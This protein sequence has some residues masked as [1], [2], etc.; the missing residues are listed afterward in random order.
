MIEA[1]IWRDPHAAVLFV[2]EAA[3]TYWRVLDAGEIKDLVGFGLAMFEG[4]AWA[5]R[6]LCA[7]GFAQAVEESLQGFGAGD[8][9]SGDWRKLKTDAVNAARP[10]AVYRR[11]AKPLAGV[12]FDPPNRLLGGE[13]L[14]LREV[15]C[16]Y[17]YL[18]GRYAFLRGHDSNHLAP[19]NSTNRHVSSS[20]QFFQQCP[21]LSIASCLFQLS[22]NV[23][24]PGPLVVAEGIAADFRL[25]GR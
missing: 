11:Q 5:G 17:R 7:L 25:A 2:R 15:D 20:V 12:F 21:V 4:A 24:I 10:P 1:I 19:H 9:G 22:E 3:A 16:H 13:P 18:V 14:F 6:R 23:L 8:T